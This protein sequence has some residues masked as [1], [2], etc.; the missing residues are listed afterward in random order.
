MPSVKPI[1]QH[2]DAAIFLGA[3]DAAVFGF[4]GD[5]AAFFVKEQ[6]VGGVVAEDGGFAVGAEAVDVLAIGEVEG[7]VFPGGAFR[8]ADGA[9]V[10]GL[11]PRNDGRASGGTGC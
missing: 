1:R 8:R 6:A 11:G 9:A 3:C 7:A 5:E 2:G 10:L 4:A